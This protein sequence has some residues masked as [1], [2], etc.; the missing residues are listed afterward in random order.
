MLSFPTL[1]SRELLLA[2]IATLG[3]VAIVVDPA[4]AEWGASVAERVLKGWAVASPCEGE[5]VTLFIATRVIVSC[6]TVR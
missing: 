5:G 6:S 2:V 4:V 3:R 1:P